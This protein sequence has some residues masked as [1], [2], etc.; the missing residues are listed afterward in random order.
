M[1]KYRH[2]LPLFDGSLFISDGGLETTL[3]YEHGF[4]LPQFAAFTLLHDEAGRRCLKSYYQQYLSIAHAHNVGFILESPTWRASAKWGELL[5]YSK[6]D[7]DT[8]NHKAVELINTLRTEQKPHDTTI[9]LSGCTGP[10]GDGYLIDETMTVEQ[11]KA[12]HLH[13]FTSLSHT[14]A[15]LITVY[16]LS[17]IEEA[18]GAVLAA[19]EVNMPIVIGFTLE[20]D[21]NLPSGSSLKD[22]ILAVD[23]ATN[24]Y[25]SYFMIN[26]SHPTHFT[27]QLMG[28]E[29]WKLRIQAIR[30]NASIKSHTELE[31]CCE[32][33]SGDPQ[34][35]A[36][37]YQILKSLLPN[38]NIVGGCCGTNQQHIEAIYTAISNK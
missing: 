31:A 10:K 32:I 29:R 5:G 36:K 18:I 8:I 7:I 27:S 1:A 24:L 3:I 12:Y 22:A 38:M 30:A 23:A 19:Q 14:D 20:T 37:Q 25:A 21:G 4:T 17:Y 35:L 15:D 6:Q 11:A 2:N 26:C 33:D 28:Q 16:T 13:Q 9:I 34:A